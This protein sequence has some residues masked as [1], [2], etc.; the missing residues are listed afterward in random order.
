MEYVRSSSLLSPEGGAGGAAAAAVWNDLAP[1]CHFSRGGSLCSHG[2]NPDI[3]L[4]LF[5]RCSRLFMCLFFICRLILPAKWS[6]GRVCFNRSV[7]DVWK[8]RLCRRRRQTVKPWKSRQNAGRSEWK[9]TLKIDTNFNR[10]LNRHAFSPSL[11]PSSSSCLLLLLLQ[12]SSS[13]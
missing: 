1:E 11:L 4:T 7:T 6:A 10:T 12:S 8:T 3:K 13:S 5:S 9:L 2:P